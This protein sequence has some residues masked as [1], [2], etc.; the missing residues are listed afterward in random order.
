MIGFLEE[1][2]EL[3]GVWV[4]GESAMMGGIS[5]MT[6]KTQCISMAWFSL[7]CLDEQLQDLLQGNKV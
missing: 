1:E 4:N 2:C 7:S 3:V 5:Y 6:D